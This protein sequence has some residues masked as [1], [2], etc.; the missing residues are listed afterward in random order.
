MKHIKEKIISLYNKAYDRI[1]KKDI[2]NYARF[3][4]CDWDGDVLVYPHN[5]KRYYVNEKMNELKRLEETE[6]N[7]D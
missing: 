4:G 3:T 7:D 6:V 2:F 1:F 5:K